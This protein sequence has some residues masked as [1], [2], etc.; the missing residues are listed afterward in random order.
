MQLQVL[1]FHLWEAFH[2]EILTPKHVNNRSSGL[3]IIKKI[4]TLFP[5]NGLFGWN[6]LFPPAGA[7]HLNALA[8][9]K[10]KCESEV[11]TQNEKCGF[12][13][14]LAFLSTIHSY[15][16]DSAINHKQQSYTLLFYY[17]QSPPGRLIITTLE[18][19]TWL[20]HKNKTSKT[21]INIS[22]LQYCHHKHH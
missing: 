17:I 13:T 5:K 22:F 6:H 12:G 1:H 19:S 9:S 10:F 16:F 11:R 20:K 4:Y 14:L 8:I 7:S 2:T 3:I 18:R 15:R 21:K